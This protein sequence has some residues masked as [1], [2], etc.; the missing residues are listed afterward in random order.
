MRGIRRE[1]VN[2][3]DGAIYIHKMWEIDMDTAIDLA[4]ALLEFDEVRQVMY[5]YEF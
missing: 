1:F 5:F 3:E 2:T 4:V